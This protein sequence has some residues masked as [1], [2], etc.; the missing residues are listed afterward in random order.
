[1]DLRTIGLRTAERHA[2]APLSPLDVAG[3]DPH[4]WQIA[5]GDEHVSSRPL[6][7]RAL[8]LA[9]VPSFQRTRTVTAMSSPWWRM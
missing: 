3:E 2:P 9:S 8:M 6:T 7:G 4:R 1:M 5:E